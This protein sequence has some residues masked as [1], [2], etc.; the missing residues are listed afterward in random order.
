MNIPLAVALAVAITIILV[1]AIRLYAL[2]RTVG[3]LGQQ[4]HELT[5]DTQQ[6]AM[7]HFQAWRANELET[8]KRELADLAR[9]E[10]DVQL[11]QWKARS[12]TEIRADAIQRS[13]AVIVGKVTEHLVPYLPQFRYN[14]KDARFIGSPI[15]L[16]VFDGLDREAVEQVVFIEVKTGNSSLTK[17][18]R[19]IR[20]AIRAGK[21]TWAEMRIERPD[22]PEVTPGT[23]DLQ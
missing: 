14:P 1:L 8:V 11:Q 21:V 12:E 4:L 13:Q 16:V 23:L 2:S 19:Q 22:A 10:A 6:R 20:D 7:L 9:R 15:D 5:G 17:R 18:E 3:Q